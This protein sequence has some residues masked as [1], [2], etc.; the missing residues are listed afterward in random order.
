MG[1]FTRERR[2]V[3]RRLR[4]GLEKH[5]PPNGTSSEKPGSAEGTFTQNG[6]LPLAL[7]PVNEGRCTNMR[8]NKAKQGAIVPQARVST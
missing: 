2:K 6:L 8:C 4:Q 3:E 7:N 5:Q 1:S